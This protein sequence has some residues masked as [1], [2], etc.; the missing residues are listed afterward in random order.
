MPPGSWPRGMR[1]GQS[2]AGGL[3]MRGNN[4]MGQGQTPDL[5]RGS[6]GK[7]RSSKGYVF[8]KYKCTTFFFFCII[9]F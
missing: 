5:K 2:P 7:S 1:P 4:M 9:T 8:F 3:Q 6:D